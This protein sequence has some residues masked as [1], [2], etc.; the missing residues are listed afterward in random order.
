MGSKKG[1]ST[2]AA[3]SARQ[4]PGL[5]RFGML[6][7]LVAHPGRREELVEILIDATKHLAG[8]DGCELYVINRA[9]DDP[10]A[11]WVVEVWR[12]RAAHRA[13]LQTPEVRA[14]IERAM[15]LIARTDGVNLEPV[16]GLGLD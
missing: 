15:P 4:G 13:S 6:G 1:G 11:I 8:M 14:A 9:A 10:D 5:A 12:D 2:S 7:K 3:R 16:G